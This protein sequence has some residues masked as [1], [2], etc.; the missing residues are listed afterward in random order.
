MDSQSITPEVV[1]QLLDY[2]PDNGV[3]TWRKRSRGWF[4]NNRRWGT[5]NSRYAGKAAGS[6]WTSPKTGY[7]SRQIYILGKNKKEHRLI[8][9]W[10]TGEYPPKQIDHINRDATDNRWSNIRSTKNIS[11]NMNMSMNSSN[12]SGVS[13]V[14]WHKHAKKWVAKCEVNGVRHCLGY[15]NNLDEAAMEVME[16]RADNGFDPGHGLSRAHY[17]EIS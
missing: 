15:F 12:T 11:N 13:G 9:M 17:S 3:L 5:W 6:V 10:M 4:K 16:F 8:W 7:Q 2:N 1:R 14:C